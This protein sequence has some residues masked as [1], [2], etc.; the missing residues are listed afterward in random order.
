MGCTGLT[1]LANGTTGGVT[2]A[3]RYSSV[4]KTKFVRAW[5]HSSNGAVQAQVLRESDLLAYSIDEAAL[6]TLS[7]KDSPMVYCPA[8]SCR[9][10]VCARDSSTSDYT[11]TDWK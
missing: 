5:R 3:M 10:L 6:A 2:W 8:G 11:C 7:K 9:A 1:T 4:C